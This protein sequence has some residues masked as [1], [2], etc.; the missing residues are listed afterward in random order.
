M[1]GPDA[2][3][4]FGRFGGRFVPEVLVEPLVQL[5]TA[6]H[7]AF[8]DARFWDEYHQLLRDFVG[9]PSPLT[10]C[11]NLTRAV[12]G[13]KIVL[14]REDCN[15]TG[16]HK[17]NNA[18]GQGLLAKRMGRRRIIAETGA[19]QHGVA[20]ATV[21]ALLQIPVVVYMGAADVERQALNVYLMRLLGAKV[22]AV[23]GGSRTLKD[24]INEAMRD[25]AAS[26]TTSFYMVGSA[27]GPHPYPFMV[28]EFARVIGDEARAQMLEQYAKLP[29]HV[30]ACV[31]GGSNAL[32]I[33]SAFIDDPSVRLWGVEAAGRG[34]ERTGEHAA[35]LVAGSEGV[36]HGALTK[37]LQDDDGQ[38]LPTHSVS[39]GLDYPGVG[40]EHARLQELG[41]AM[42][43]AATDEHARDAF[44][45]LARCEGIIPALESAHAV[46][47]AC[48]LAVASPRDEVVLVNLSGRGDKD[49]VRFA[50]GEASVPA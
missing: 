7:E 13:A 33:F 15:H 36:L 2:R 31:G 44:Q 28:R 42:Y 46:A 32:G 8:D 38:V 12:G 40:P 27:V 41:R 10:A 18:L 35:T 24:A 22:K 1:I 14:K 21:G 25:W 19:G 29:D 45:L 3:G 9:R 50:L 16:A 48:A 47:H 5:E 4:Y 30:V 6:M 43:V 39:A 20:A 11:E 23:E 26:A 37:L 17:I 49:A 34:M